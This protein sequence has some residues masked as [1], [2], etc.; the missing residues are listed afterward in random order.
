MCAVGQSL[1]PSRQIWSNDLQAFASLVAKCQFCSTQDAPEP[2]SIEILLGDIFDR[3]LSTMEREHSVELSSERDALASEDAGSLLATFETRIFVANRIQSGA[4]S[5]HKLFFERYA[6]TYFGVRQSAEIDSIRYAIDVATDEGDLRDWCLVALCSAVSR[7]AST[8]GHFAQPL[9]PKPNNIGKMVNQRRRSVWHEFLDALG[10]LA[11]IGS[12]AWRTGN[13]TFQADALSLL[14][15]RERLADV[16]LVYADPPYTSD[17]YSRY[18]HIYETLILYDY[19]AARGRGL[20][21]D[22][23]AVSSFS[24]ATKVSASIERLI[25][26]V[27]A[28]GADLIL[29]YPSNGLLPNSKAQIT[30][31]FRQHYGHDPDVVPLA[32]SHSTMGASK[33]TA[34]HQVVELLYRARAHNVAV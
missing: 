31:M 34:T 2:R 27:H 15:G 29:S 9:T 19:P 6:G 3:H 11:A 22:D 25:A 30:S 4:G 33:G 7:C 28:I 23:R 20:Y 17:Q 12:Q 21:R 13:R 8:T 16:R 10:R 1:A 18:Y 5:R 26:S 24:H 32:H 14:R